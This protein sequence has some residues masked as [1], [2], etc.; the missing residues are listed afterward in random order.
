MEPHQ[1]QPLF[2]YRAPHPLIL[3]HMLMILGS[4][5]T[6]QFKATS[7]DLTLNGA[8]FGNSIKIALNWELKFILT[9]PVTV[10]K[11]FLIKACC[12][13]RTPARP[14]RFAQ[15]LTLSRHEALLPS[16]S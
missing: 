10:T 15:S 12:S 13:L 8:F 16:T 1:V 4:L 14:P 7:P 5:M 9:Y 3:E 6:G 11:Y 2:S